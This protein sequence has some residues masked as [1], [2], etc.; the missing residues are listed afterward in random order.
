L[1]DIPEATATN[2]ATWS[3]HVGK[4]TR[5]S[6]SAHRLGPSRV[7]AS[8]HYAVTETAAAK[9]NVAIAL[10]RSAFLIVFSIVGL[11]LSWRDP[12]WT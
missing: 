7:H 1:L 10:A 12:V 6:T 4:D 9:A 8:T 5:L 11:I 3:I 2:L